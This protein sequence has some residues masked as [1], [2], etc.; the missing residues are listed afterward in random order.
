LRDVHWV[1]GDPNNLEVYGWGAWSQRKGIMTLRNPSDKPQAYSVD[2]FR[3][4][5]LPAGMD[6]TKWTGKSPW[7]DEKSLPSIEFEA[8]KSKVVKLAP[9]QVLT[10]E[11]TK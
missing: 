6:G 9:F 11:L 7:S 8:G 4:L 3:A 5:E 2:V 10:L 1:G